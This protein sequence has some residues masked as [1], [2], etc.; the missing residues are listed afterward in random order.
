M[1]VNSFPHIQAYYIKAN[2]Y[3]FK[4]DNFVRMVSFPSEKGLL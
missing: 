4:G 1:A 2:E 3:T